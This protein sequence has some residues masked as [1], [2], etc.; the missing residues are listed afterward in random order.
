MCFGLPPQV[1]TIFPLH[2]FFA[3]VDL[4]TEAVV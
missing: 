3:Q 2:D 1:G 4:S